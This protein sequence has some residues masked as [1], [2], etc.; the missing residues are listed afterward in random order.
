MY[1]GFQG[2]FGLWFEISVLLIWTKKH[3]FQIY[4]GLRKNFT[5]L[6]WFQS[7]DPIFIWSMVIHHQLDQIWEGWQKTYSI[8]SFAN[9]FLKDKCIST[10]IF[11]SWRVIRILLIGY[12]FVCY[13]KTFYHI[14]NNAFKSDLCRKLFRFMVFQIICL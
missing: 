1:Q 5:L 9:F 7:T 2:H 14:K 13:S 8:L 6:F 10:N 11:W 3:V 12:T 4:V